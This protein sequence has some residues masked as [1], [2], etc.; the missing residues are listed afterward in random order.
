M[1]LFSDK[2]HLLDKLCSSKNQI[3]PIFPIVIAIHYFPH[4]YNVLNNGRTRRKTAD[5]NN[6]F[7]YYLDTNI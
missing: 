6:S 7:Q 5:K 3:I 2:K 4:L 1:K